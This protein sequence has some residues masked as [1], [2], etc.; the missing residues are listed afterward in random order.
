MEFSLLLIYQGTTYL[1]G[2]FWP[3]DSASPFL[4]LYYY[5]FN[6]RMDCLCSLLPE[7]VVAEGQYWGQYQHLFKSEPGIPF[8]LVT[9]VSN[10]QC[11]TILNC[12]QEPERLM[13]IGVIYKLRNKQKRLS[14]LNME[15]QRAIKKQPG[16]SPGQLVRDRARDIS[17]DIVENCQ[18]K[19]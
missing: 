18:R 3:K 13:L 8:V 14:P 2:T 17:L 15:A 12:V 1:H 11:H 5:I 6:T 7:T 9:L 4:Y 19:S 10:C 16:T